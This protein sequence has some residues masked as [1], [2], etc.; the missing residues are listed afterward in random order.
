M[1]NRGIT[2]KYEKT[3][4]KIDINEDKVVCYLKNEQFETDYLIF[5]NSAQ[6]INEIIKTTKDHVI[7][8]QKSCAK[9]INVEDPNKDSLQIGQKIMDQLHNF[10]LLGIHFI[11]LL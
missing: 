5:C 10:K 9:I 11:E 6:F 7:T 3:I 2:T 8:D 1:Q 4:E